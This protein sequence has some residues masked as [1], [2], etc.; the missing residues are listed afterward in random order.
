MEVAALVTERM[1]F[2]TESS[3]LTVVVATPQTH[4]QK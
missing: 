2:M 1:T 3:G 4:L